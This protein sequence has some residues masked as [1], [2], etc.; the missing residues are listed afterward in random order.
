LSFAAVNQTS[1]DNSSDNDGSP[2]RS[3]TAPTE[4]QRGMAVVTER[5]VLTE[6]DIPGAMLAE[7]F[8]KH[9]IPK[10]RWWLLCRGV[11]VKTSLKKTEIIHR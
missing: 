2:L 7:P 4:A 10:L 6:K 5:I 11:T 8:N 3:L 9:T 1:S